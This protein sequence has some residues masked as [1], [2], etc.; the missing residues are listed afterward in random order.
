M[1][2][3]LLF[4]D[5]PTAVT[6]AKSLGF[7][8]DDSDTL[9]TSGQTIPETGA[10][11]SWAID[12]IGQDPAVIPGTYDE[13]GN[14]LTPPTRLSGYAVNATGE[15]PEAAMAYA[16]PYGS[17]GRVFAGGGPEPRHYEPMQGRSGYVV[18]VADPVPE[19]EP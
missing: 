16:I 2:V 1:N 14:E 4:P 12:E 17:A 9:R 8:D 18:A 7:W 6:A 19:D 5:Y 15:I 10:P 11:Y 3:T 13:E